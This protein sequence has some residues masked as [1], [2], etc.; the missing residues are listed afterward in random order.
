MSVSC[1]TLLLTRSSLPVPPLT[2]PAPG[3]KCRRRSNLYLLKAC[4][5]P[6][7]AVIPISQS[8]ERNLGLSI[9]E[10]LRDFSPLVDSKKEGWLS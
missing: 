7:S 9:P 1:P 5:N 2:R 3:E 6:A 4:D 8:L 10:A